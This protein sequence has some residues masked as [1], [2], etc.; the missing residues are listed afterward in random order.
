MP[1]KGAFRRDIRGGDQIHR[2]RLFPHLVF[3]ECT[4]ARQDFFLGN[5]S[6]DT[7]NGTDVDHRAQLAR[8]A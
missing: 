7:R 3:A 5:A 2:T 6:N 8:G 1:G 4:E